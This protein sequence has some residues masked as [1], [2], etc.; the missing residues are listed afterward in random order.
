M[1][2]VSINPEDLLL[3]VN[4]YNTAIS[5]DNLA[6]KPSKD[7]RVKFSEIAY[8]VFLYGTEDDQRIYAAYCKYAKEYFN[9]E[10]FNA[11][12]KTL[13]KFVNKVPNV[14]YNTNKFVETMREKMLKKQYLIYSNLCEY[15]FNESLYKN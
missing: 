2:L 5:D 8:K 9:R 15:C 6:Y 13:A 7:I 3:M 14:D 11:C 10:D 1:E 12:Y 4:S